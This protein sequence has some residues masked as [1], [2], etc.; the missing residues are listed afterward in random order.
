MR[1]QGR[2]V[3]AYLDGFV[4][5]EGINRHGCRPVVGSVGLLPELG[6][7]RSGQDGKGAVRSHGRAGDDGE[8]GSVLIGLA[9]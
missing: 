3:I 2:C 5:D 9:W 4:V 1:L 8:L 6:P 7:P